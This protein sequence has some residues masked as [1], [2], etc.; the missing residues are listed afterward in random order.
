MTALRIYHHAR[1]SKSRGA[2]ALVAEAGVEAEIVDYL[3]APPTRAE[4]EDLLKKLGMRPSELIRRGEAVFQ[5]TYAGRDLSEAEA[6]EALLAH[7][8]LMERPIV[9]RGDRALVARPPERVKELLEG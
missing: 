8:I 6:L 1:C 2:C 5:A 9:V 7:P 3:A 4:L